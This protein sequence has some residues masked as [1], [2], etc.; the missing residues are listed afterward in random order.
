MER[1]EWVWFLAVLS[2]GVASGAMAGHA[3]L[4]GRLFDWVFESG[5]TEMFRQHYPVFM[6]ARKPGLLFDNL[7]TVALLVTTGY[8]VLLFFLDR[9]GALPL[10][11][12][13]LQWLFV[14]VFFGTGFASLERELF[15]KGNT[16]PERVKR[17]L[18]LNR[19]LVGLS[20][21]LLLGSFACLVLMR[22]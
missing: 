16:S 1:I 12:A 21:F 7:F 10:V 19:P 22:A 6:Q 15:M 9:I 3:L 5:R 2:T 8:N 18:S 11:A 14:A 13:G 17:F 4:L 20:A